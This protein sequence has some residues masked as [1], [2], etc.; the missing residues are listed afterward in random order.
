MHVLDK[1][2]HQKKFNKKWEIPETG[3]IFKAWKFRERVFMAGFIVTK[4]EGLLA[5]PSEPDIF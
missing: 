1:L 3:S 5:G 2:Y 4:N